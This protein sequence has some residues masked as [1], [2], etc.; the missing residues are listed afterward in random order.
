MSAPAIL[1][2][3]V[4]P[5]TKPQE[6]HPFDRRHHILLRVIE[7]HPANLTVEQEN[8]LLY[9]TPDIPGWAHDLPRNVG[10]P[11]KLRPD[12]CSSCKTPIW[13]WNVDAWVCVN[14]KIHRVKFDHSDEDLSTLDGCFASGVYKQR[15]EETW[16]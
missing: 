15:E 7:Q 2:S 1:R 14:E 8:I 16:S 10:V 13:R 9:G 4:K 11:T 12:S 6:E 5:A 3:P